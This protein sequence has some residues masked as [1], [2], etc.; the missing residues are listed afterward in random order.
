MNGECKSGKKKSHLFIG[1]F[2]NS[3]LNNDAY[4]DVGKG[5]DDGIHPQRGLSVCRRFVVERK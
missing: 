4:L 3:G 2:N 5:G 1:R